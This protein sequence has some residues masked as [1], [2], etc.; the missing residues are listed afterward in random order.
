MVRS[1]LVILLAVL[2]MV[3]LTGMTGAGASAEPPANKQ[4]RVSGP[5]TAQ[6]RSAVAATG[7]AIDEVKTDSVLVTATEAEVAAIRRLGF[8]VAESP[9]PAPPSA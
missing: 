6:Q 1:R 7:A 5:A 3:C 4:Y 8:R 2:G 9:R